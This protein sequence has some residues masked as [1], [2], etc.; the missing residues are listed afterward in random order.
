MI[1]KKCGEQIADNSKFCGYCGEVVEEVL[2]Q[3]TVQKEEQTDVNNNQINDITVEQT[4]TNLETVKVEEPVKQVKESKKEPSKKNNNI[5]IMLATI[6]IIIAGLICAFLILNK[7]KEKESSNIDNKPKNSEYRMSGNSLEN[8]DLYFL[9]LENEK[10]NKIYS[11]LS[12]KYALAM[13]NEGASRETKDEIT[14]VIGDYKAKKYINSE[15]MSLANAIFVNELY[16]N[17]IKQEYTNILLNKYNAE[18]IFDPFT[19]ADNINS[20]I[21]NKTLKLI[22]GAVDSVNKETRFMLVNALGIDME[23]QEKFLENKKGVVYRHEKFRWISPQNVLSN[24][25]NEN[26]DVS[27][28]EIIASFNNYDIVSTLGEDKIRETVGSEFRKYL[29]DPTNSYNYDVQQLNGDFSEEN[30]NK[31]V[32]KYLD[33]Y[34]KEINENYKREDSNTDFSFYIDDTVKAFSKKLK[35]YNGTTLEYIGIMPTTESLDKFISNTN[36]EKINTILNNLKELKLDNF[37]DGAVTL[38]TGF[39][40]KFKFDYELN[41]KNDLQK[42]GITSVFDVNKSNLSGITSEKNSYI[43]KAIHKSNIEFTQ[44]GIKAAATTIMGGFGAGQAFDYLYEVPVEE[45]DLTFDKPYM[46]II[47]DK[48]TKE[49]WFTGTVYNPLSVSEETENISN[50]SGS[51]ISVNWE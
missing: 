41:L 39:I 35:E 10:V 20:C 22:D 42:L 2:E 18:V 16:K 4:N 36:A 43:E 44:D 34:I 12:I 46:F 45:I 26:Q 48:E 8:F 49:V 11:P 9:Q 14:A 32:N 30:I 38:I 21:S 37:K 19:S 31:V 1:C 40:P 23:W 13:L 15:N 6:L 17:S 50:S 3:N 25:F 51:S 7:D 27:G 24:K 5:L 28:M 33:D 47:R 29:V